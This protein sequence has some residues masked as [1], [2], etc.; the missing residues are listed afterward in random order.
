[1]LC[2]SP[3]VMFLI[4]SPAKI[5]MSRLFRRI[6]Q[7]I[8]RS[9]GRSEIDLGIKDREIHVSFTG[10]LGAQIFSSAIYSD[11][12]ERGIPVVADLSYFDQ[13]PVAAVVGER[14]QVSIFDWQLT[15][16]GFDQRVFRCHSTAG[17]KKVHIP[18]GR[19]KLRL[20][21]EALRKPAIKTLFLMP[22]IEGRQH[23]VTRYSLD[24]TRPYLCFHIRRGDYL[25]VASHL[26]SD[27]FFGAIAGRFNG[28]LD[29]V[30]VVSDSPV[31]AKLTAKLG[32]QFQNVACLDD[33]EVSVFITHGLMRAAAILVC[34]NSQFS[35]SAG[36]L[37]DGLVI[38]PK[39]WYGPGYEDLEAELGAL[40][41]FAIMGG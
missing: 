6:Q 21:L 4:K 27:D 30:L 34:S 2:D 11:F 24:L 12:L 10:G 41:K 35:L 29:Q 16:L 28:L 23:A 1:M 8:A 9:F 18:D 15:D 19:L 36:L 32:H 38:I 39:V 37:S 40:S 22:S 7:K 33:N 13:E 31:D 3:V 14:G 17:R 26:I 25:N 20:A 5:D